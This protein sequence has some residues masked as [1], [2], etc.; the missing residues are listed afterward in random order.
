MASVKGIEFQRVGL[1]HSHGII[2]LYRRIRQIPN[3]APN[4]DKLISTGIPGDDNP[5]LQESIL[6]RNVYTSCLDIGTDSVCI[7]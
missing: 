3:N 7:M 4:F 1:Q 2:I 6:K 5:Q